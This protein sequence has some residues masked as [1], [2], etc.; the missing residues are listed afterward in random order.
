M[1]NKQAHNIEVR[2]KAEYR[3]NEMRTWPSPLEERMQAFLD[4]NFVHY[5]F[6]KIFYLYAKDGWIV[7][8]YIADFYVPDRN[9]IIEV[10]GKFHKEHWLRD[11]E[12]TKNIQEHYPDIVVLRYTW[13]DLSDE[14]KMR[15]LL[16]RLKE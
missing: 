14:N 7:R 9:I 12:R 4:K 1:S 5:E 2:S 6:Q 16:I 3:A 11:K 8:Y 15:G 13:K 10:D